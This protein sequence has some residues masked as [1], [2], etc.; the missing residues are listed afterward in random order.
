MKTSRHDSQINCD[1]P[2][3]LGGDFRTGYQIV[4]YITQSFIIG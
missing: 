3:A 1:A 4:A 2:F